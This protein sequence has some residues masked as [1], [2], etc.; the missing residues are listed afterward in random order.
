MNKLAETGIAL[1]CE[2]VLSKKHS[3][4]HNLHGARVR[5][6]CFKH[7]RVNAY[8]LSLTE[9][10]LSICVCRLLAKFLI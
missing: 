6:V 1:Q 2:N 5:D 7:H 4:G 9:S 3:T 8:L 10:C